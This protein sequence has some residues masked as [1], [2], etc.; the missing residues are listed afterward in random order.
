MPF[1]SSEELL[2]EYYEEIEA[3][4]APS[5]PAKPKKKGKDKPVEAMEVKPLKGRSGR[6]L[7]RKRKRSSRKRMSTVWR[8]FV[9]G[10]VLITAASIGYIVYLF[11]DVDNIRQPDVPQGELSYYYIGEKNPAP[12]GDP[13]TY[14]PKTVT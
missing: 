12:V 2:E 5:I 14:P 4:A 6:G 13:Y 1:D 10:L 7:F 11:Y 8:I 9:I 3:P